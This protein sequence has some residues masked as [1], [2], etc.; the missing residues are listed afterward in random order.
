M[1]IIQNDADNGGFFAIEDAGIVK[2]RLH[3]SLAGMTTL[4]IN[5]TEVY[6][7]FEHRGNGLALVQAVVEFARK[8][9]INIIPKCSFAKAMFKE[10]REWKD[11]LFQV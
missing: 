3:Y 6:P 8:R 9:K 10:H 2:G 4:I 11:V 7:E 1:T 5:H